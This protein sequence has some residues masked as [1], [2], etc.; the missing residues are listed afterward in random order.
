[1]TPGKYSR[2]IPSI[3]KEAEDE[4]SFMERYFKIFE[5]ILKGIDNEGIKES[6]VDRFDIIPYLF[7]PGFSFLFDEKEKD[8]LPIIEE[9]Q[10]RRFRSLFSTDMNDFLVFLGGWIGLALKENWDIETKREIIAKMIPLYRK[11]GTKKGLEEYLKIFTRSDV[12]IIEEVVSFQVGIRSHI[13]INTLLGGLPPDHFMVNITL[14]ESDKEI[15]S[16][17]KAIEEI[18]NAEKPIHIRYILNIKYI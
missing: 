3:F 10:A 9:E 2:F 4:V 16:K 7:H 8:F 11:R 17:R 18:I 15:Q 1:M 6:D 5:H 12:S 13:G 14:P